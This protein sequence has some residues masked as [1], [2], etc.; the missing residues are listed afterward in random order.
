LIF[1]IFNHIFLHHPQ[2]PVLTIALSLPGTPHVPDFPGIPSG[3]FPP[4]AEQ[5]FWPAYTAHSHDLL[6]KPT[7]SKLPAGQRT[8]GVPR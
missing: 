2:K 4:A 8:D 7:S 3:V 6:P 5:Q 1:V